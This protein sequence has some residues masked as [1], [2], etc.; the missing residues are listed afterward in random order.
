MAATVQIVQK[1]GA[2]GTATD[3]TS[4]TVRFKNADD[5]NVD[6][7]NPMVKPN[8][9]TDYSFEKWLRFKVTGGSYSQITNIK[10]YSDGAN[11]LGTGIG[12]YAKAVTAYA[13][14]AEATAT[15]GYTDFFSY[16]S[17][18][19]LTLGTGPYTGTGEKGDHLVMI[20]TVGST[21]SGGVTPS[22]VL[23]ISWDEI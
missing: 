15:T 7:N 20:L 6:L 19:P 2:G 1:N 18:S 22:E 9:G 21:A 23:N 16:D 14:P 12:L 17:G 8:S 10:A 5:A 4:G 13:P 11:G 3:V